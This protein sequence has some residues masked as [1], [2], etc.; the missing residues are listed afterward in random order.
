MSE[1]SL[2]LVDDFGSG[3]E[4]RRRNAPHSRRFAKFGGVGAALPPALL[5]RREI[6]EDSWLMSWFSNQQVFHEIR[7][8]AALVGIVLARTP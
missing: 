2:C 1:E 4:M 7:V 3:V 5:G 8:I 6:S